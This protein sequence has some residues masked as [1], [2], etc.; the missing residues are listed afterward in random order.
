MMSTWNGD[1]C[2]GSHQAHVAGAG[3]EFRAADPVVG[4]DVLVRDRPPLARGVG[5]PV[6]DLPG[7]GAL[8]I[9]HAGLIGAL[10]CVNRGFHHTPLSYPL[11]RTT[12]SISRLCPALLL[13]LAL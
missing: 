3:R 8:L 6:L 4:V 10:S 2:Q 9:A 1:R 5:F 11:T 7:D 13:L 12:S